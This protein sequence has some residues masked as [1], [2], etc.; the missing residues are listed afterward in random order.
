MVFSSLEYFLFLPAVYFLHRFTPVGGR[1]LVLLLAS[2]V[3]YASLG[4]PYLLGALAGVITIS[5]GCGLAM[6]SAIGSRRLL[7]MWVGIAANITILILL[8]YLPFFL[9]N[10][11]QAGQLLGFHLSLPNLPT[12]VA[13]GVSYFVFQAIAYLVD[14]YTETTD[15]ERHF[16]QFA[17][18]LALFPK[19]L[20]GPVERAN[21]LLPQLHEGKLAD[22]PSIREGLLLIACGLFKKIVIADRI[23]LLVDAVYG[24]ISGHP[25]LPLLTA[26]YAYAFQIF[27]DFSGYTDMALGSAKL[28]GLRLSPNFNRPYLATSVA[29]FWRRW[30]MSFSRWILD[31][32]F[33]PLQMLW[34][35]AGLSGSAAALLLTFIA[36]GLWHGANWTFIIWGGLHGLY[37]ACALYYRPY[38]KKLHRLLKLEKTTLLKIWQVLVTFHLV[39]FA[40][41]FFRSQSIDDALRVVSGIFQLAPGQKAIPT[42]LDSFQ[43]NIL[44]GATLFIITLQAYRERL[45][46][47]WILRWSGYYILLFGIVFLHARA[48]QR[49]IYFQF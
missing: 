24:D 41:I 3:F 1:Y 18:S 42:V 29:E 20:Q 10:I 6:A 38:Q 48:P 19:L 21:D 4:V 31:Y 15:V 28:F 30:H 26:T 5:F 9:A 33:R 14:L 13:I 40:W 7:W 35:N 43:L 47:M 34:R 2:I 17:L 46:N 36:S 25:G 32:L 12:L 8:R 39:C 16:G 45:E 37:M 44:L 11:E 23:G 49:F 22:V 27:F